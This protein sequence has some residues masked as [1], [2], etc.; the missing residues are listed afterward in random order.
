MGDKTIR[1]IDMICLNFSPFLPS[2]KQCCSLCR[3]VH[4][5]LKEFLHPN[6]VWRGEGRAISGIHVVREVHIMLH[7]NN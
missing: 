7:L 2:P 6:I 1:T 3:A 5:V 4:L